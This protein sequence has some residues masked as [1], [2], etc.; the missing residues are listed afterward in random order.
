M[1]LTSAQTGLAPADA[2]QRA[3]QVLADSRVAS[4]QARRSGV[5]LGF[6]LAAALLAGAAAAWFAAGIGG[7]HRDGEF[8]PPLRW[9]PRF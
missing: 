7:K 3:V 5:I 1:R 8:A 4:S 9:D 6:S 2:Q